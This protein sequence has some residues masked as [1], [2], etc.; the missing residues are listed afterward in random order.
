MML[1]QMYWLMTKVYLRLLIKHILRLDIGDE[2]RMVCL[3]AD[4][5]P[6][7]LLSSDV[8]WLHKKAEEILEHF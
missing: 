3:Y 4:Y 8:E 2:L 1:G 7:I 5:S 6:K